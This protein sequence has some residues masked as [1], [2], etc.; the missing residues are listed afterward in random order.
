MAESKL[1]GKEYT[2]YFSTDGAI[3][4]TRTHIPPLGPRDVLIRITHSGVCYADALYASKGATLSLGHEGV[5][6]VEAVGSQV[7]TLAPGDRAGGGFHRHSCGN[8]RYCLSGRDI[9]CSQR[10]IFGSGDTDNGTFSQY[11]IGKE[12]YVHRI[13]D[14]LASEHAA[15]LQCAGATVYNAL[16]NTIRLGIRI[17]IVGI[18]GLGHLAIQFAAHLSAGVVALSTTPSKEEEARQFGAS[19]FALLGD[20]KMET[21]LDVVVITSSSYPDWDKLMDPR[22]LARDGVVVPLTASSRPL[23]LP[24]GTML[25]QGYHIHS[26]L[27]A[28]RGNHDEMLDFAARHGI[29]PA[30]QVFKN[31]GA[32]SIQ[33]V[34]DELMANRIRYRVILEI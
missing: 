10:V 27:V 3:V 1:V 4:E 33:Y 24:A 15:P 9:Y 25:S 30:V 5:G 20:V 28:S 21:P 12:T 22:V 23:I 13:P 17:G 14:T 18:G 26:S 2:S 31:I 16:K 11:Y 29:R 34:I 7:T 32:A 8:C 19:E 6:I